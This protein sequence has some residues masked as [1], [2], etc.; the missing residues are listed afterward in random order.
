MDPTIP[1]INPLIRRIHRM[2]A[3][4]RE[5]TLHIYAFYWTSR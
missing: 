3:L 4:S 2:G 5:I 1:R